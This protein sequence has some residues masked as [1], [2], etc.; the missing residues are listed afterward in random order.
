LKPGEAQAIQDL[1]PT[2]QTEA[3]TQVRTDTA[4]FIQRLVSLGNRAVV[5]P[6]LVVLNVL[7]FAFLYFQGAGFVVPNGEVAAHW[8]SNFGPMTLG[9][10]WWRLLTCTFIHFGIFHLALNMF[11]L[12]QTGCL[13]ERMYGSGY[14]LVLYLFAGLSGSVVSI[15]WHPLINSAGASGAIFGVF[16][17]LLVFVLKPDTRVPATVMKAT[18]NSTIGFV[19]FNLAN[20]FAHAGIDNGAH[21]GGLVGGA[22]MGLLLARPLDPARRESP[23]FR[24]AAAATLG[25]LLLV[26]AVQVFLGS[27]AGALQEVQFE[28]AADGFAA[29]EA[30]ALNAYRDTLKRLNDG[31][32]DKA[33]AAREIEQ[34]ILPRWGELH[35]SLAGATLKEGS[36]QR[37]M[38]YELMRYCDLR[39]EHLRRVS[40]ALRTGTPWEL[41]AAQLALHDVVRQA[42][43][44]RQLGQSR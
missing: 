14:F 7:V 4:E 38:Q 19:A 20:G 18:R 16:G 10:Q 28:R 43:L 2:R 44:V 8:G 32:L 25:T 11:A 15:L 24:V 35:D 29:R 30:D 39:Q 17:G 3:F 5:T 21:L 42:E 40:A 12:Y 1:L 36:R 22:L 27:G 37:H 23:F 34:F 41:N 13:V 9:G 6:A 26:S 31:K 33:A